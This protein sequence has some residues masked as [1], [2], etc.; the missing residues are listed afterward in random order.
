MAHKWSIMFAVSMENVYLEAMQVESRHLKW[1]NIVKEW[2]IQ[3]YWSY[4]C[5]VSV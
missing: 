1:E 5:L 2:F 3:R 4:V